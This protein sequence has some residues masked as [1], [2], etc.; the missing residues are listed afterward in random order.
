MSENDATGESQNLVRKRLYFSN[1]LKIS[2]LQQ[3]YELPNKIRSTAKLYGI[4]D[5]R[6]RNWKKIEDKLI[7]SPSKMTVHRGPAKTGLDI[8]QSHVIDVIQGYNDLS[9][10]ISFYK[11]ANGIIKVL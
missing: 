7:Q 11:L 10:S 9:H 8:V 5:S 2:I 6:I 1:E 4:S 3:A